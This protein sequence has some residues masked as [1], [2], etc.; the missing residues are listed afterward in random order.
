MSGSAVKPLVF[1]HRGASMDAPENTLA[2]FREAF[3]QGA[4][5][6]E[7]DFHL[8]ADL[9]VVCIHDADAFRTGG[10]R[11]VVAK[12]SLQELRSLEYGRW[13]APKFQ[14]EPLPLLTELIS[15][16]PENRWL[17]LELKAGSEIVAPLV[18]VLSQSHV[19]LDRLLVIAFDEQVIAEF[20]RRM[21]NV[22]AHWLTDFHWEPES[23]AWVPSVDT[24]IKTLQQCGADGLGSEN[25]PEIVTADFVSRLRSADVRQFH[26]WTVDSPAE[27]LYYG[28]LGAF[29]VTS[30]CPGRIREAFDCDWRST[31]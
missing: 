29:A 3:R 24:I 26:I 2:A 13:K 10:Q 31:R 18:E 15:I 25:R 8:T 27:A 6:V 14:G 5:G 28:Q 7:G 9:H 22:L 21:P 11:L 30:N 16:V 23:S 19:Q 4:D 1:G 17:V 12:S 20:K